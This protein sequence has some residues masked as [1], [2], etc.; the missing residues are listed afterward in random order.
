MDGK[1][2]ALIE[3][4]KETFGVDSD[5][6]VLRSALTLAAIASRYADADHAIM[7]G[8]T[9]DKPPQKVFLAT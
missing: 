8:P 3:R 7:M 4:L 6:E 5:A 2:L 9:D 1:T